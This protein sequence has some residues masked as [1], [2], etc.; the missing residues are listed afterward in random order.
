MLCISAAYAVMRCLCV[1]LCVCLSVCLSDTF[2]D[3]VKTNKRIFRICSPSIS[4]TT[5][6]FPYQ[7]HGTNPTTLTGASNARGYEKMTIFDQYLAVSP[8]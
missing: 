4:L 5:L 2:V 6:V 7:L 1:R 8:K 3:Y